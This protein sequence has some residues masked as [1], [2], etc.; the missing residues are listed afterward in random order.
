MSFL[1][2]KNIFVDYKG[3]L[4]LHDVSLELDRE[5]FVCI[6]GRNGVGKTTLL[7]SIMGLTPPKAG[8]IFL[9]GENIAGR[10]PYYIARKGI[11]YIP[12]GRQIFP[13]LTVEEN[14]KVG[15]FI[16]P[17]NKKIKSELFDYFPFLQEKLKGKAGELSG[18]QQQMLAIAR[19]LA[20]EPHTMILDEPT[21]G[22][23]PSIIKTIIEIIKDLIREKKLTFI[24]VE[25]NI[26]FAFQLSSRGYIL[27][28]GMVVSQG[29]VE[30]LKE[31]SIVKSYLTI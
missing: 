25:Q 26:D 3:A 27:E 1:E 24:L 22:I 15:T 18:G 8:S 21:E 30:S 19:A 28:K 5:E 17:E 20:G 7:R 9:N 23:Q 16:T 31:D 12:Q 10:R 4:I 13:D 14:L 6:L 11:S 2:V 29:P